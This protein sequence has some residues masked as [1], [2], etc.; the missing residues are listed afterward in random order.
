[1]RSPLNHAKA[2]CLR[3]GLTGETAKAGSFRGAGFVAEAG[4][5]AALIPRQSFHRGDEFPQGRAG[6][7]EQVDTHH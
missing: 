3:L 7:A 6:K 5:L 1:M 4:D 2:L